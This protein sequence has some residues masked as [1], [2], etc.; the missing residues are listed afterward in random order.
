MSTFAEIDTNGT[1]LRIIVA[2]QDYVNSGL[3]GYSFEWVQSFNDGEYRKQPAVI[4]GS[5]D[6]N[7]DIFINPQP[8]PSYVLSA[9]SD[10]EAPTPM[11]SDGNSW[12]W[13]EETTQWIRADEVE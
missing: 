12:V 9:D 8:Y 6:K 1:V 2:E 3:V 5:Y 13:D 10:W 7:S 4:G 11:P